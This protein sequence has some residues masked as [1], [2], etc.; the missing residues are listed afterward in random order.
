MNCLKGFIGIRGC[1]S[2]APVSGIYINQFPGMSNELMESIAS[3]DQATYL[4]VWNDVQDTSYLT[5]KTG[6]QK[7]LSDFANVRLDQVIFQT[8]K[9]FNQVWNQIDPIAPQNQYCGI[10]ASIA[11]GKY[12]GLRVKNAWIYNA[13]NEAV[14]DVEIKYFQ[15]QDCKQLF[16]KTV[17][18][19]PG[20]NTIPINQVFYSDFDKIEILQVV[21]CSN[22]TT[23]QGTFID[24]G[25]NWYSDECARRYNYWF[26][27]GFQNF[28]VTAPL[29]YGL[30]N[31]WTQASQTIGIAWDAEL[32]CSIDAFICGQRE[33]LTEAWGSLLSA[34]ILRAKLSS[35]RVNYFSNSNRDYTESNY[36]T[37]LDDY[38]KSLER[39]AAQ[40]NLRQEG[41]CF[42]CDGEELVRTV[43]RKP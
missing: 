2:E 8:S 21:D 42:A 18:L 3:M 19:E 41:L 37:F 38:N 40:L 43:G 36:K 4:G 23:L 10:M 9:I 7:K 5:L 27:S 14:E 39:W 30:G 1:Q 32:I 28:P 11:G 31:S 33:Y 34:N 17:T 24:Y 6:I 20:L 29:D 22:L 26:T 16:S 35:T 12:L 13:G 15:S 25:W